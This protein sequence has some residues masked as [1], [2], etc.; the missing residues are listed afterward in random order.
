MFYYPQPAEDGVNNMID[1]RQF[2]KSL[3]KDLVDKFEK[4]K[5]QYL[6]YYSGEGDS[7]KFVSW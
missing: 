7:N 3:D 1:G 6:H 2:L 5:I 4:T